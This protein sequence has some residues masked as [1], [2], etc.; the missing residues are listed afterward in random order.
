MKTCDSQLDLWEFNSFENC[1]KNPNCWFIATG[2]NL[3]DRFLSQLE[4]LRNLRVV[5][6]MK[7]GRAN[8]GVQQLPCSIFLNLKS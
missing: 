2:E 1:K 5:F 7:N 4:H 6:F 8:F 3:S